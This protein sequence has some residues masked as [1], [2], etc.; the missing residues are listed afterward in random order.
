MKKARI[1]TMI[2]CVMAV[3]NLASAETIRGIN[4][5]FVTIGYAGNAGDTRGAGQGN[6][7]NPYG[8]GAVSYDYRIGKYEV[9]NAQWNAFIAIAGV[10]TGNDDAYGHSPYFTG[11]QQPTNSVSWYEAAQFCNY[12]TSGDKSK[13]VY[14]FSGNNTNPGN[15]LGVNRAAAKTTYGTIYFIPTEDEWYKAAYYTGGYCPRYSLYANGTDIQPIACVN[16]NYMCNSSPWNVGT[17]TQ[18]QNGTFDMMGNLWEWTETLAYGG[19]R[20][21]RGG[22]YAP[23]NY[24]RSSDRIG[25]CPPWGEPVD[26]GFRVASTIPEPAMP[27]I[28]DAGSDQTVTDADDNGSEQVTLDGSGST[29]S[30][31]TIQSYVWS[32]GGTQIAAGVNPNITLS[33]GQH[34]I[35]LTVTDDDGVTDTD[36]VT[37]TIIQENPSEYPTLYEILGG[38]APNITESGRDFVTLTSPDANLV[39]FILLESA[40]FANENV[41]GIY[42][43]YDPQQKLQLFAGSDSP[44][45]MTTVKFNATAGT[46]ENLQTGQTANIGKFFGFYLTTP[47]NGGITYYTDLTRNP[48]SLEHGLIFNTSGFTGVI[49][50]DPDTVIAFEDFLGLGDRDYNDMVVGIINAVP[51]PGTG[52]YCIRDIPGDLNHD[53]KVDSE[54]FA[55]MASHWLECNLDPQSACW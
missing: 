14:Q 46:A 53:C 29:D 33:I 21:I 24:L 31:G 9:T 4:I 2:V 23:A 38:S 10:P 25:P 19:S 37:I 15:F 39:A 16:T 48:D 28:A 50:N 5:D 54:D 35:T 47:Q 36:T 26:V 55:I 12:L 51:L 52:P 8:C 20:I 32:E 40:G 18:E 34:T 43:A 41:F 42:S 17:G 45:D 22:S 3:A 6:Y 44:T 27:P 11:D 7:A 1:L 13:G 30:D 49:E